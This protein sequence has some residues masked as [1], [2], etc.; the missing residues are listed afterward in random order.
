[1]YFILKGSIE[2]FTTKKNHFTT[3]KMKLLQTIHCGNMAGVEMMFDLNSMTN[4][5]TLNDQVDCLSIRKLNWKKFL[6]NKLQDQDVQET[7]GSIL[8]KFQ[9]KLF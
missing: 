9:R 3:T 1:M 7:F 2:V 4:Y 8:F 5:K 6:I